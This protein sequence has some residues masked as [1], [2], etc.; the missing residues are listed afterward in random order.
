[1]KAEQDQ[2]GPDDFDFRPQQPIP[3]QNGWY[4]SIISID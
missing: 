1:M 2:A 4:A 3:L